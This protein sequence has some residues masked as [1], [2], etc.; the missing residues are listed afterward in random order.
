MQYEKREKKRSVNLTKEEPL[1]KKIKI[2]TILFLISFSVLLTSI[3]QTQLED[4]MFYMHFFYL[5]IVLSTFWWGRRGIIVSIFLGVT[6]LSTSL[7]RQDSMEEIFTSGIG[8][9]LFFIVALLVGILSDEK[10]DALQKEMQ[11]KLDTAH[12]FFNPICIVEGN[13]DLAT[14]DAPSSIT[15]NL[16]DAQMAIQRIKKIV[17]NVVHHGEI[18]E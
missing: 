12:Y 18:H 4:Y 11:F 16:R 15:E 1:E 3:F 7:L 13:I 9:I 8:A 2:L 14:R 6:L 5:P 17:I 10:N